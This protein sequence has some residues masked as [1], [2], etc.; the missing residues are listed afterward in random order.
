MIYSGFE[1]RQKEPRVHPLNPLSKHWLKLRHKRAFSM[2]RGSS[3]LDIGSRGEKIVDSA[4]SVDID[5]KVKPDIC[6]TADCLPFRNESFDY[7]AMLEVIEHLDATQLGEALEEA[8]RVANFIVLSTPNCESSSW[9]LVWYLWS[10]SLGREW[11]GAHKTSFDRSSLLA[12]LEREKFQVNKTL[13]SRWSL[14]VLAT[15]SVEAENQAVA[16]KSQ[17]KFVSTSIRER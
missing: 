6:A 13:F 2:I 12:F 1:N 15:A 8:K 11:C 7:I 4:V 3:I 5:R 14:L 10:H 16:A 9:K 17:E